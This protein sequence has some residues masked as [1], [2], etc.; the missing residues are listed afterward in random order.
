MKKYE[1]T[2]KTK[3][4]LG[5]TLHQIRALVT[6]VGVVT[7]GDCGGW[8]EKEKNLS[9]TGNAWVYGDAWVSGDAQVSG[10]ARVS[11]NAWVYGDAWVYGA[12]IVTGKQIGRAS[13]RERV[14][15]PV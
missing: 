6:I 10:N 5:V 8:I 4:H 13:C 15:S 7:A 11:G 14:S 9:H 1:F 3:T 12:A 2:G